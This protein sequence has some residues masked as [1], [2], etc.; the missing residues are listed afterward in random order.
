MPNFL[1]SRLGA[2]SLRGAFGLLAISV[3]LL[4]S[5]RTID[6]EEVS[7]VS[8]NGWG[9]PKSTSQMK[10]QSTYTGWDFDVVWAIDPVD[11]TNNFINGFPWFSAAIG[12]LHRGRPMVGAIWCATSWSCTTAA[13]SGSSRAA[14]ALR[15]PAS[16][17]RAT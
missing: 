1:H 6:D 4:G 2:G 7:G 11:G 17:R 5:C 13:M 12:V 16:L 3:G 9:V 15:S 8:D 10:T 14:R